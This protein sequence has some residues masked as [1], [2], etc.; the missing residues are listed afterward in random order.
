MRVSSPVDRRMRREKGSNTPIN[1]MLK[2][3]FVVSSSFLFVLH[4]ASLLLSSLLSSLLLSSLP[5]SSPRGVSLHGVCFCTVCVCEP[6][7]VSASTAAS[8]AAQLPRSLALSLSLSLSLSVFLY[9]SLPPLLLSFTHFLS[10]SSVSFNP[11]FF[12][13]LSF[14]LSSPLCFLL[15]SG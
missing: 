8:A 10:T 1:Y 11:L 4:P 2:V 13:Q 5:L 15:M 14:H 9:L 6:P 3:W 12:C 7:S